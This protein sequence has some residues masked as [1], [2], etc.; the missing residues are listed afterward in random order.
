MPYRN[1][2]KNEN[3]DKNKKAYTAGMAYVAVDHD[4]IFVWHIERTAASALGNPVCF[5]CSMDF[6]A[7]L[8]DVF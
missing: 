5:G 4:A 1:S 3:D 2:C 7:L 6:P 8:A